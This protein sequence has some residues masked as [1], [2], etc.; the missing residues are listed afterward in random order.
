MTE[1]KSAERALRALAR[2][3]EQARMS[4]AVKLGLEEINAEIQLVRR[5]RREQIAGEES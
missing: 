3:Q 5:E 1:S 4:G 2:L